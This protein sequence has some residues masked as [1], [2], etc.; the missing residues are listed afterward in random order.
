MT[1][2]RYRA[3]SLLAAAAWIALALWPAA[4]ADLTVYFGT[5]TA[6]PGKGFSVSHFDTVTGV[7]SKPEF[8]L[9]TPAPAYYVIAPGGR[10][11]YSCNSTGFV[12]AYSIDPATA[13]L[14]LINQKP[15]GGGDP[16]YI[17][18]DRTG[19]YVFAANYDG[20]N[21]AVWALAP[22]G[23]LGERTAFVQH[24][25]SGANPQQQLQAHPHSIRVDPTNR[26]ALVGDTGLDKLF[27][28]KFNVKDGSLTPNDPPFIKAAPGANPRHVAFHPNERW[29]YVLTEA[30]STI[31]LFNWDAKRGAMS[32]VE[33]VST[34]PKD[35]Q[36]KS[37]CAEIEV[38]PSGRFVYASNRGR[39]SIAVFSVDAKTGRLTP[40]QDV[41]SG[42]KTPRNFD[43]DPSA[44]WLLVTN[45]DSNTAMVFRID[46]QTGKLTPI[47]QPVD[48]PSPYCPRFLAR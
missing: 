34:L 11:L 25:D 6:G 20:G 40:I 14:K 17:S 33:T 45:H 3:V 32:E 29:L 1:M 22:D 30:G 39:D 31:M 13:Q 4:A 46:Q 21:I 38:H 16:S 35:F 8:L 5:H 27:V 28:Y 37:A 19:H 2:K 42:G 18:L 7:L 26:F 36:G 9:E 41:P 48:V 12:S 23:S 43:M 47:G 15:S 44:H 10:R 24:T